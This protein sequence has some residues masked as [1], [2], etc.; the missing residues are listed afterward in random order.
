MASGGAEPS[1]WVIVPGALALAELDILLLVSVS[2]HF[3]SG[4]E[5]R[6]CWAD[7]IC[8]ALFSS[9]RLACLRSHPGQHHMPLATRKA[10]KEA[11]VLMGC[12]EGAVYR[13]CPSVSYSSS[14]PIETC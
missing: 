1:R 2:V 7:I 11:I 5:G 4:N 12:F 6:S 8:S 10:G 9:H 14:E 13:S 3:A